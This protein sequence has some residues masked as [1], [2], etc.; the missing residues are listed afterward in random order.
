MKRLWKFELTL[1]D[2]RTLYVGADGNPD[3]ASMFAAEEDAAKQ[4]AV[5]RV[6]EFETVYGVTPASVRYESHGKSN[7][8]VTGA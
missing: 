6:F 4:E 5:R 7:A 2:G 8:C 3:S 1:E